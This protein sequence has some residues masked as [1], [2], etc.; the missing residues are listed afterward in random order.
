MIPI[1]VRGMVVVGLMM[2]LGWGG[3]AVASYES[4]KYEVFKK[5]GDFEIRQYSPYIVA[6][7]KVAGERGDAANEAFRILAGYIF[8]KNE[9]NGKLQMT[10]PVTQTQNEKMAMTIP[11]VQTTVAGFWIVQFMM[12]TSYGLETLPRPLDARISL[13]TEQ[14][15]K[16]VSIRFSGTW[17]TRNLEKHRKRLLEYIQ[18][19]NIAVRGEAIYS[20]YNA[21][22][23]PPFSDAMR[24]H[25]FAN[26]K[27]EIRP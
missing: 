22:F 17:R 5:D 26:L 9:K 3:V 1:R 19:E 18:S 7:V 8:G 23:M 12:P 10:S 24:L 14:A 16:T 15:K 21:P 4:P 2:C 25:L 27:I 6:Q 13:L 11:V 20:F